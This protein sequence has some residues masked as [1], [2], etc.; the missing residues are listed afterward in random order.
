MIIA[1]LKAQKEAKNPKT[2]ILGAHY[3]G[4]DNP[5]ANDNASGT[6][7]MM[8]ITKQLSK[9]KL[10]HNIQFMAFGAEEAWMVGSTKYVES[11]SKQQKDDI[12][13]MINFDM[14][15]VGDSLGI[16][17]SYPESKQHLTDAFVQKAKEMKLKYERGTLMASDQVPF[18]DAGIPTALIFYQTDKN[19]H[20][21]NDTIDKIQKEDLQNS[22]NITLDVLGNL[23]K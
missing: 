10:N 14:V 18:E 21:D 12:A 15:G 2:Y 7:T 23:T 22:L 19:Y 5:A 13:G 4:V 3:D 11:L 17:T 20:T 16:F 9:K 8:E 1:T 6:A